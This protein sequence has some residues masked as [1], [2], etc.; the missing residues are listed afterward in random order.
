MRIDTIQLPDIEIKSNLNKDKISTNNNSKKEKDF[1]TALSNAKEK[2]IK[3][4]TKNEKT[5]LSKVKVENKTLSQEDNINKELE[6]SEV[7]VELLAEVLY[8]IVVEF[9]KSYNNEL[10]S[11]SF[12]NS[13]NEFNVSTIVDGNSQIIS[14]NKLE[15]LISEFVQD[16]EIPSILEDGTSLKESFTNFFEIN[17]TSEELFNKENVV[18]RENVVNKET[19]FNIDN[20]FYD[21]AIVKEVLKEVVNQFE[22]TEIKNLD[23][24]STD[25]L[26]ETIKWVIKD[27][28]EKKEPLNKD[29]KEYIPV[30][31]IYL[32]ESEKDSVVKVTEVKTKDNKALLLSSSDE[33]VF[34]KSLIEGEEKTTK[35]DLMFKTDN[36]NFTDIIQGKSIEETPMINKKTMVEDIIKAIKYMERNA[37]KELTVKIYPKELGEI[38]IKIVEAVGE[39]GIKANI[40]ATSKETYSILTANIN[41]LKQSIA[42]SE[43]KISEVNISLYNQDTTF[44]RDETNK[45]YGNESN[46]RS[47]NNENNHDIEEIDE[48][49]KESNPLGNLSMLV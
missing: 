26:K 33:E 13:N 15:S 47:R 4:P 46:S 16:L 7:E 17:M 3:S 35:V 22:N 8:P 14:A 9:I 10:E 36:K 11:L 32:K 41:E 20:K 38:S 23:Y 43:I 28:V 37:Q 44:H 39:A 6:L 2:D 1:S 12:N 34:L 27:I 42:N 29:V 18:N 40:T 25:E 31:N 21:K 45:N 19:L 48:M 30:K 24:E 5:E 49:Q